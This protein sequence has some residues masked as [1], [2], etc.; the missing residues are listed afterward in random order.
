MR[1]TGPQVQLHQHQQYQ[2]LLIL[3]IQPRGMNKESSSKTWF[4]AESVHTHQDQQQ[5]MG[6]KQPYTIPHTGIG[7]ACTSTTSTITL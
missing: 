2:A 7:T 4:L 3:L 6:H 5:H 1:D